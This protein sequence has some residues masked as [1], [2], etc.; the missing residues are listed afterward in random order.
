MNTCWKNIVLR[1]LLIS[2]FARE[3]FKF[4]IF[5]F[6]HF[7]ILQIDVLEMIGNNLTGF[8][9]DNGWSDGWR[10]PAKYL[11]HNMNH[12]AITLYFRVD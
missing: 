9:N 2:N 4:T 3:N 5:E 1:F 8:G 10:S 6:L 12:V 7:N 11:S